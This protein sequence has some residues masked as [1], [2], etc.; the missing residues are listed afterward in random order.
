[1]VRPERLR[2]LYKFKSVKLTKLIK[3]YTLKGLAVEK[4]KHFHVDN[5]IIDQPKE[6]VV[7][8]GWWQSEK[9]FIE[10]ESKIREAFT[11]KHAIL[12]E[13]QKLLQKIQ[14]TDSIC[15]NVRRTDFLSTP[16][17]N[18]T[19]LAYFSRAVDEM[20]QRVESP[21]FFIFSDDIAWCRENLKLDHPMTIVDHDMK[22]WKFSNYLQLMTKCKNFIIPNSSFAWWA[23]WLCEYPDKQVVAPAKWFNEGDFDTSDLVSENWT[24]L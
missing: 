22:G 11:F 20:V 13:S 2:Q 15:L 10:I 17:L 1:M 24:R 7:Y 21:H 6:Q 3:K 5:G 9:Y 18:A 4:E 14:S 8:D 16:T 19:N 23:V 12:P